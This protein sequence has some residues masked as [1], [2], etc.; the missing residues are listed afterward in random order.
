M[1]QDTD[2]REKTCWITNQIVWSFRHLTDDAVT[3]LVHV[4]MQICLQLIVI[5]LE[6]SLERLQ[7]GLQGCIPILT[8]FGLELFKPLVIALRTL[9]NHSLFFHAVVSLS[10]PASAVDCGGCSWTFT[11]RL[12]IFCLPQL[13]EDSFVASHNFYATPR[14]DNLG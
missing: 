14:A 13:A 10:H 8:H 12:R 9:P 1:G 2:N 3:L 7:V 6:L 11:M 4:P 5:K